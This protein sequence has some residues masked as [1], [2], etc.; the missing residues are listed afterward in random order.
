VTQPWDSSRNSNPP[1]PLTLLGT[2]V[3]NTTRNLENF[4]SP[5]N[6]GVR[7]LCSHADPRNQMLADTVPHRVHSFSYQ[8]S[9]MF[10]KRI[11]SH[12]SLPFLQC[13]GLQT[14]VSNCSFWL[15][16]GSLTLQMEVVRA[17]ETSATAYQ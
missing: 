5:V 13:P 6:R 17:F 7:T 11:C 15:L 12:K 1:L 10:L 2:G 8:R 3:V 9:D 4:Y 14:W 16:F